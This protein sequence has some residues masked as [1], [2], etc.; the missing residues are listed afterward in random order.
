MYLLG[1]VHSLYFVSMNESVLVAKDP[2][3]GCDR[4][5][6]R[7]GGWFE[8][9]VEYLQLEL[10][11]YT[12]RVYAQRLVN[13]IIRQSGNYPGEEIEFILNEIQWEKRVCDVFGKRNLD[14]KFEE[15]VLKNR[16][17]YLIR[18]HGQDGALDMLNYILTRRKYRK[19]FNFDL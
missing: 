3:L 9:T 18:R 8:N 19:R 12:R 1:L 14:K 11:L 16:M 5:F 2:L 13:T 7:W 6:H 17:K 4:R 15:V 10:A